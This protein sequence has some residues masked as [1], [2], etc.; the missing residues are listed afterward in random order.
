MTVKELKE[1]VNCLAPELDNCKIG[2]YIER[3]GIGRHADHIYFELS[4]FLA[5]EPDIAIT[6]C[7]NEEDT[8]THEKTYLWEECEQFLKDIEKEQK[9]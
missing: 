6:M 5:N 1:K 8:K 2:F 3:D 9:Q 7:E 4:T